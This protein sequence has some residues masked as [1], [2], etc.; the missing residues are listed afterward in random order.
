MSG[1]CFAESS[2]FLV[3]AHLDQEVLGWYFL[4]NDCLASLSVFIIL[5][6]ITAIF[7][8]A[9]S[10]Q[11]ID[12]FFLLLEWNWS[13]A[14]FDNLNRSISID[15]EFLSL[16][17]ANLTRLIKSMLATLLLGALLKIQLKLLSCILVIIVR[18][19]LFTIDLYI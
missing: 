4:F 1:I 18:L 14:K 6:A 17:Q 10:T 2:L 9:A 3:N 11:A 15:L 12:L 5:S 16:L 13:L 7:G 8:G 19:F